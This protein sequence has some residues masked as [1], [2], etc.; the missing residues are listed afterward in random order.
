MATLFGGCFAL[1]AWAIQLRPLQDNSFLWHLRTG[2]WIL[3]HGVP[4][5]DMFSFTV[6]GAPWVVQSWLAEVLYGAIDSAFGPF[7]LRVLRG[8]LSALIAFLV[9]KLAARLTGE[10]V[11]AAM[12]TLA[13]LAVSFTLWSER[14]L[15]L[16]V[17]AMV[18]LVWTVEVPDSIVGRRPLLTLPLLMWLWA[19]VHGTFALGFG[20]LAVH[21]VGCWLDGE[22][23]WEGHSR[24]LLTAAAVALAVCLV[25]PLG[26]ALLTFP[27]HLLARGD[28]LNQILEWRSPDFHSG[29]GMAFALWVVILVTVLAGRRSR[30]TRRD[31]LVN[32]S[33]LLLGFW[34]VRNLAVV[35]IVGLAVVARAAAVDGRQEDRRSPVNLVALVLLLLIGGSALS[36]AAGEKDYDLSAYPVQAMKAVDQQ[37]LLGT[38]LL[39][40]D[41]WGAYVIDEYWPRQRVF[42]DDRYD[43][44]P[45]ELAEEYF[46]L[47]KAMPGWAD[48]LDRHHI[49]TIVWPN[50]KPLSQVLDLAPGW[51]RIH[52]DKLASV[53]VRS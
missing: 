12:I 30:P 11:R 20:Y 29:L 34:A 51:R 46:K 37:G 44:Y 7:G 6:P 31:I 24:R 50:V 3:G 41:A 47:A 21:L 45:T 36:Q 5:A 23:P 13:A 1:F 15:L 10:R 35:P 27:I 8:G 28:V 48:I 18:V 42:I 43:M 17:L 16:G 25:N 14:P 52:Q 22:R 26:V 9:Y 39:T 40:T 49:T 53:W 33:F 19:N 4:R 38:E 32:V 2:H